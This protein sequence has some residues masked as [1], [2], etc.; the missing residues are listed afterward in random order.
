MIA[1]NVGLFSGSGPPAFTAIAI[2]L[3]NLVMLD[4]REYRIRLMEA[5]AALKDAKAG[6]NERL[7][8]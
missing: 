1:R 4:D 5:E 3:P 2:C 6:A 7:E 8:I